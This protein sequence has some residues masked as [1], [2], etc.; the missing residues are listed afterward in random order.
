MSVDKPTMRFPYIATVIAF[1][2]IVIMLGLGFWQL[3]RKVEKDERLASIENAKQSAN[4]D[5]ETAFGDV[6]AFQDFIVSANGQAIEKYFYIDNKLLDGR[7]G[8]HVLVPYKTDS[9]VVMLNL[10]WLPATGLRSNMPTFKKPS[11]ESV[12]GILYLPQLNSLV[13]ETNSSYGEF[14]VLLQQ[15]D[16]AEINKHLKLDVLPAVLRLV[17]EQTEF[18][19]EWKAVIMSPNKH[20][21][22]AVQWFGL[23]IAALT[24]Y[25][26]SMVKWLHGPL[27]TGS[28]KQ[29]IK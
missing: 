6:Q 3:D 23:A 14:P 8:F 7:V 10:G 19:R 2:A 1:L 21:A 17:S 15:V 20:L 29:N 18:K 13:S 28:N 5:M 22:Y 11:L 16:L 4:I 24:I 12:Q 25:L 26:L 27:P 9:G